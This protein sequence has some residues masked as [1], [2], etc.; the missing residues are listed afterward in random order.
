[1]ARSARTWGPTA[2]ERPIR[3]PIPI[4]SSWV[5]AT[6]IDSSLLVHETLVAPLRP[7]NREQYYREIV[8]ASAL[9]G[10]SPGEMPASYDAFAAYFAGMMASDTLAVGA[11]GRSLAEALLDERQLGVVG[12]FAARTLA[13]STL[14]PRLREAYGLS[15]TARDRIASRALDAALRAFVATAPTSLRTARP[16]DWSQRGAAPSCPFARVAGAIGVARP[17][18]RDPGP[19]GPR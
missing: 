5:L 2:P 17:V 6:L 19:R 18:K 13:A 16:W 4:S 15:W 10:L 12:A 1:M 14:P 11:A 8:S 7:A 9:L 3:R